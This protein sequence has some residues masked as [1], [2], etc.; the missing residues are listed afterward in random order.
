MALNIEQIRLK[1]EAGSC[2][3]QCM[4][5][6]CYLYGVDVEINYGEA[7]RLLSAAARQRSSRAVLNLARMYAK[8]LGIQQDVHQAIR[9][10]E[11]VATP[12]DSS[13]A[14]ES[15]I[16]L[17]RIFSRGLGVPV[18]TV[19]AVKWYKAAIDIAAEGDDLQ[20]LREARDYVEQEGNKAVGNTGETGLQ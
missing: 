11:S 8:G 19:L 4:L 15:R 1:A 14:F 6:L 2:V 20:D 13:D 16:E 18:D 5:G 9:Y 17:G 12:S 10:F 7:F 3:N